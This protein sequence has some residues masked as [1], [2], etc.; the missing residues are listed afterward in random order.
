MN[1]AADG[2][3]TAAGQTQHSAQDTAQRADGALA[4][5][6]SVTAATEQLTAS[7]AEIARQVQQTADVTRAASQHARASD[8]RMRALQDTAER[9]GGVVR[10]INEIAGQT[11]LLALNATIEAARA[12]EAGKGFAVVASEVKQLAAQTARATEDISAQVT[13]VREVTD[14]VAVAVRRMGETIGQIEAVA[15]V[16][17]TSIDQQGA[18]TRDIANAV[19]GVD[20]RMREIT[21]AMRHVAEVAGNSG[22]TGRDVQ[23]A[24]A[25][26]SSIAG[27]LS[28]E[29]NHFLTA[30]RGDDT[31]RRRY[32]RL[33]GNGQ[34][35]ELRV[36]GNAPI[37]TIIVDISRGGVALACGTR[38]DAG[39]ET[40]L[41]AAGITI[42]GRVAR[43][44]DGGIAIAF[45][46]NPETLV[47]ADRLIGAVSRRAA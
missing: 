10:L 42:P 17:A 33:P 40:V 6:G 37:P 35:A 44:I 11:N 39:A 2:M 26:V 3:A 18:A 45:R 31:E 13:E 4:D 5:L 46:Q 16:I 20:G 15:D 9:I 8:E 32:E 47:D 21:A 34:D 38:L 23:E 43:A 25:R 27:T 29:V 28:E 41:T 1:G 24:A 12:G 19:L 22:A 7:A 30:V 14:E 36:G